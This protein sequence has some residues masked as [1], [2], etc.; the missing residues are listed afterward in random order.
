MNTNSDN[1]VK[2]L[3][4]WYST[5]KPRPS[6]PPDVIVEESLPNQ[7]LKTSKVNKQ[8]VNELVKLR[9]FQGEEWSGVCKDLAVI[10]DKIDYLARDRLMESLSVISEPP[11]ADYRLFKR[12]INATG[13]LLPETYTT[14]IME[15]FQLAWM[16]DHV[17]EATGIELENVLA[18]FYKAFTTLGEDKRSAAMIHFLIQLA[19]KW[20]KRLCF[21]LKKVSQGGPQVISALKKAEKIVEEA[22]PH[23]HA[24]LF[25]F[26][27]EYGWYL[28]EEEDLPIWITIGCHG[29]SFLRRIKGS[30][31]PVGNLQLLSGVLGA[32]MNA[33]NA[34][35][36]RK[37][38]RRI[39][40][41]SLFRESNQKIINNAL[42]RVPEVAEALDGVWEVDL[43]VQIL[44]LS[45]ILR[46]PQKTGRTL[47]ELCSIITGKNP[48]IHTLLEMVEG[49][50]GSI[51]ENEISNIVSLS[52]L[53]DPDNPLHPPS[54]WMRISK[55]MGFMTTG[56]EIAQRLEKAINT[57]FL[58]IMKFENAL[59][60]VK[61][62]EDIISIPGSD[63]EG[64]FI[65]YSMII[66]ANPG[67]ETLEL[68]EK[69]RSLSNLLSSLTKND[70]NKLLSE[71]PPYW[72]TTLVSEDNSGL[73][74][75][76]QATSNIEDENHRGRFLDMIISPLVEEVSDRDLIFSE[77]LAAAVSEYNKASNIHLLR[78]TELDLVQRF[79][80]HE[81]RTHALE[82]TIAVLLHPGIDSER[83]KLI[84]KRVRMIC[85]AL[86]IQDIWQGKGESEIINFLDTGLRSLLGAFVE[87]PRGI[88]IFEE[89]LITKFIDRLFPLGTEEI[90]SS[91]AL[92]QVRNGSLF[93]GKVI[94]IMVEL[95]ANKEDKILSILNKLSELSV[96]SVSGIPAGP[97]FL[98]E[99]IR[100]GEQF[101][102][103][104][105]TLKLQ[106]KLSTDK[107]Y[108]IQISNDW[109]D[110][111]FRSW[112][113]IQTDDIDLIDEVTNMTKYL[114]IENSLKKSLIHETRRLMEGLTRSGL[115]VSERKFFNE[116]GEQMLKEICS[117]VPK[118]EDFL[119]ILKKI[120]AND[121]EMSDETMSR[122][123]RKIGVERLDPGE[124][125][126][127][128]WKHKV[129]SQLGNSMISMIMLDDITTLKLNTL[130]SK[131]LEV[132]E[133]LGTE[134]GGDNLLL[135]MEHSISYPIRTFSEAIKNMEKQLFR[136]LWRRRAMGRVELLTAGRENKD[137]ITD[138]L[139]DRLSIEDTVVDQVYFLRCFGQLFLIIEEAILSMENRRLDL[140][141]HDALE[142]TWLFNPSAVK[143]DLTI[144]IARDAA[145]TALDIFMQIRKRRG[146]VTAEEADAISHEMKRHYRDNAGVV[147]ILLRWT[148]DEER[149]GILKIFEDKPILLEAISKDSELAQLMDSIQNTAVLTDTVM[150][151]SNDPDTLKASLRELSRN[152]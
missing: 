73:E 60:A 16:W 137:K 49:L 93:F 88:D 144:D 141:F 99:V 3:R 150:R 23:A 63:A 134:T 102:I 152:I 31:C 87:V 32:L 42:E 11:P 25:D 78:E 127:R 92:W 33:P 132:S 45:G 97:R 119:S 145:E 86:V 52:K 21:W 125:S 95:L 66:K 75:V 48:D 39:A 40:V 94:P 121:F 46:K 90:D 18:L 143:S 109:P 123:I 83:S 85:E 120:E 71:L 96:H 28:L 10:L 74:A 118:R 56:V 112:I 106:E 76:S 29:D 126:A 59:P 20:P 115:S 53:L 54:T 61:I 9:V 51:R 36:I 80:H 139:L 43:S 122:I 103:E 131:F 116:P 50:D 84:V 22:A 82:S 113:D 12:W 30:G 149:A 8:L 41:E 44:S 77:Y 89:S 26:A 72:L 104:N 55:L 6:Q 79:F 62:L 58:N 7:Y 65:S 37:E 151:L 2:T 57:V 91:V 110:E 34:N 13:N 98:P 147:A 69:S 68:L 136:P 124:N 129:F 142:I 17:H 114:R 70:R 35:E 140:Y 108:M 19:E 14:A 100:Q 138:R 128:I 38:G 5:N 101:L 148:L 27:A 15:F 111:V 24:S 117:I 133:F 130:V 1:L 81:D 105:Y 47:V 135:A 4:L 107:P 64:V 67:G 146:I